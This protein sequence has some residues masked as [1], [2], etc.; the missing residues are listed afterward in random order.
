MRLAYTAPATKVFRAIAKAMG[1]PPEEWFE[2]GVGRGPDIPGDKG[3]GIAGRVEHLFEVF[4]NP[5]T[6]KPYLNLSCIAF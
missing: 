4:R 1:F 5:K 3:R 2:E 6:G